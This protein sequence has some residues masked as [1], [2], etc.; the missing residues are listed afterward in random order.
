MR[1]ISED[2]IGL[3][4]GINR[5]AYVLNT[6]VNAIDPT[7]LKICFRGDPGAIRILQILAEDV[8]GS[9]IEITNG[10]VVL[11]SPSRFGDD[12]GP[13]KNFVKM[14]GERSVTFTV[15]WL[16]QDYASYTEV[17]SSYIGGKNPLYATFL[18][19]GTC[20]SDQIAP[21]LSAVFAHE[22]TG[23]VYQNWVNPG[24]L[25]DEAF[26]RQD[27]RRVVST[28]NEYHNRQLEFPRCIR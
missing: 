25:S 12:Y 14:F 26:F 13:Y 20:G 21:S 19:D 10:C 15:D 24:K 22:F 16:G 8:T 18:P 2:P 17:F 27:V 11:V 7:G 4:G 6:P 5:Y 3:A 28:E 1:F 9:S 23:H